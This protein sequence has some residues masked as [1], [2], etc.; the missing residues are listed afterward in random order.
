MDYFEYLCNNID[1]PIL[2]WKRTN[3]K[4]ICKYTNGKLNI[5][6]GD[7]LKIYINKLE[8]ELRAKY[9]YFLMNK[10]PV[11]INIAEKKIKLSYIN[12]DTF[13]EIH[14]KK[15]FDLNILLAIN[16]K[17]RNPLM[18]I[19]GCLSII[20]YDSLTDDNL[21]YMNIIKDSSFNITELANDMID[22]LNIKK[23]KIKP[24]IEQ[25]NITTLLNDCLEYN[26]ELG[27]KNIII[28]YKI[29]DDVPNIILSDKLR[30]KQIIINLISNA[31]KFTNIGSIVV[32]ISEFNKYT[33]HHYPFNYMKVEPP[34]INLLF[35]VKDTGIGIDNKTKKSLENILNIRSHNII[36]N[37][38]SGFGL[39]IC[40][41][42]VEVLGGNLW[43]NTERD[44]GTIFYFNIICK[45]INN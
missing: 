32:D 37:N 20:D 38:I 10:K 11:V 4:Y 36:S 2:V 3:N 6:K 1:N 44:I 14:K 31:V 23:N 29:D 41:N 18:N 8:L 12:D 15:K 13:F 33:I 27:N 24:K 19:I 45:F 42:L 5:K 40:N 7:P 35:R 34:F 22:F 16:H 17:I 30:L 21:K 28:K 26:Y 39:T 43:F 9:N 25:I